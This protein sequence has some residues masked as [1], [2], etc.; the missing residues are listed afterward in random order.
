MK[1]THIRPNRL[2]SIVQKINTGFDFSEKLRRAALSA[3]FNSQIKYAGTTGISVRAWDEQHAIGFLK[4]R[5]HIRNH[6][7]GIHAT[8]AATLA[9]SV[10]GM[11][12][13]VHVPD[14]HVPL[15]KSI[16]IDYNRVAKGSLRAYAKITPD[17]IEDIRTSDK[18][19]TIIHVQVTDDEDKEPI[20]A[21]LEWAWRK[22]RSPAAVAEPG[23]VKKE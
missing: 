4:N 17:Q 10:T 16:Q 13:G 20:S 2:L 3:A 5:W 9:E 18:G 14:T 12:F 7:G 1:M 15:L 8:A 21:K 11:V 23:E 22:K 6:L 19:S